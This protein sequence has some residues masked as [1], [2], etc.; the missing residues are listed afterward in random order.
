MRDDS[1]GAASQ[2]SKKRMGSRNPFSPH[3]RSFLLS[4]RNNNYENR[5]LLKHYN[6]QEQQCMAEKPI[7]E[8][9]I[10]KLLGFTL[11]CIVTAVAIMHSSSSCSSIQQVHCSHHGSRSGVRTNISPDTEAM[12]GTNYYSR[13]KSASSGEEEEKASM[14]IS[15]EENTEALASSGLGNKTKNHHPSY[16]HVQGMGFQIYTGGAPALLRDGSPNPE[17]LPAA[18]YGQAVITDDD[19]DENKD[20]ETANQSGQGLQCYLGDD[21]PMMDIQKRLRILK[22]AVETAWHNAQENSDPQK[23]VLKVFV[24]PEFFWRGGRNGAYAFTAAKKVGVANFTPSGQGPSSLELCGPICYILEELQ[25]YIAQERF[26]D[27][28]FLFGTIVAYEAIATEEDNNEYDYLFYNF[29]PVYKGYNPNTT[30]PIGKRFLL[31]KRYIS[32][33]D[34]LTPGRYLNVTHLKELVGDNAL[35]EQ[36]ADESVVRNPFDFEQKRYNDQLWIDYKTELTNMG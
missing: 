34:F 33:S 18:A 22:E 25:A 26:A 12:N 4:E 11:I 17:C 2:K 28:L 7:T 6:P 36:D 14:G 1:S 21:D 31:P 15:S 9:P 27:W 29:A 35:Q 3:E 13:W 23:N 10:A 20:E 8:S 5:R 32:S 24:A 19:D 16:T 30:G